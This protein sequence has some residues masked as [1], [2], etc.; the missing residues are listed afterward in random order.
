MV[1]YAGVFETEDKAKEAFDKLTGAGLEADEMF[2]ITAAEGVAKVKEFLGS[3]RNEE[4]KGMGNRMRRAIEAG[5]NLVGVRPRL[6]FARVV[7]KT[8]EEVGVAKVFNYSDDTL[9]FVSPF[10]GL[11]T[12]IF[13]YRP[14]VNLWRRPVTE[15]LGKTMTYKRP[16]TESV[17]KKMLL[18]SKPITQMWLGKK[19][20][21]QSKPMTERLGKKMIISEIKD[22]RG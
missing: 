8:F 12:L 7:D 13:K 4:F 14:R 1:V 2:M 21:F 15:A 16:V 19:M 18:P 11:P 20:L 3:A 22:K 10:F 17:G 5:H 9:R 6:F